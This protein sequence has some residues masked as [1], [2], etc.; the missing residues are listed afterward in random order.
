[1]RTHPSGSCRIDSVNG[2]MNESH[3]IVNEN[4][5][6]YILKSSCFGFKITSASI[7]NKGN[8]ID[9]LFS[10]Q[11]DADIENII[12][13]LLLNPLYVEFSINTRKSSSAYKLNLSPVFKFSN[14]N[15]IRSYGNGYYKISFASIS[16]S[17]SQSCDTVFDYATNSPN[18]TIVNIN[19]IKELN[20]NKIVN[21][22][23][24]YLDSLKTSFQYIGR[25]I[26]PKY[27][28]TGE[29]VLF[30]KDYYN[31]FYNNSNSTSLYEYMNN[32]A[33]MYNNRIFPVFTYNFSI[34]V[35]K[36][37]QSINMI[38]KIYMNN[39]IGNYKTCDW[40]YDIGGRNSNNICAVFIMKL[41]SN[42]SHFAIGASTTNSNKSACM[43]D[44]FQFLELPYLSSNNII[45]VTLT[46]TPNEKIMLCKW[47]DINMGDRSD[48][49]VL[50][51][52]S[53]C[54]NTPINDWIC[55]SSKEN[56][57]VNN[58]LYDLFVTKENNN[59]LE[60]IYMRYDV[61]YVKDVKYCSLGY[62]NLYDSY[63]K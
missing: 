19:D 47:K 54:A 63:I 45:D 42:P 61:N 53:D 17:P 48:K 49:I 35:A 16:S 22:K 8:N 46:V 25:Y 33:L 28:K 60:N 36:G 15:G 3:S 59:A 9:I 18:Q 40:V 31:K 23:V 21:M 4:S 10:T 52:I 6:F 44:N 37:A 7:L 12:A 55:K 38:M 26:Y 1:V 29:I 39:D 30:D 24:Y 56:S 32:I 2:V 27:N 50:S 58:S 14:A 51:K 5:L 13:L 11:E 41:D 43:G 34:N 62:E 57:A 20:V